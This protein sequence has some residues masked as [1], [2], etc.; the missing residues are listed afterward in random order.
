[1]SQQINLF[2]P[3]LGP[4]K[5]VLSAVTMLQALLLICLCALMLML[6][7][8]R[9]VAMLSGQADAGKV[10]L[11]ERE[12]QLSK[13]NRQFPPRPQR[14]QLALQVDEMDATV[15]ALQSATQVLHQADFG[16]TQGYSGY[17]NGFARSTV[18]GLWLT[19]VSISS[20]G[21]DIGI[22]GRALRPELV[23]QFIQRLAGDP[24]FHGKRFGSLEIV[25]ATETAAASAA[26]VA[27]A[28]APS[29]LAFKLQAAS[30]S[31]SASA[32]DVQRSSIK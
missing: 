27:V 30:G 2:N 23:P 13:L 26:D 12:A 31:N 8:E 29:V 24:V 10:V 6:Y 9:N 5:S 19:G 4:Q 1:L 22:E 28:A 11:A 20:A 7:L 32:P 15:L 18:N 14:M 3:A 25:P 21:N 17:F 16:N